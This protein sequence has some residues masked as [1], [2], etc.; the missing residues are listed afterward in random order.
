MSPTQRLNAYYAQTGRADLTPRQMRRHKHK[1]NAQ[2][3]EAVARRE[4][5]ATAR[6]V[7]AL[8]R[9][10]ALVGSAPAS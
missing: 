9:K 3:P 4:D 10:A 2:K 6:L 5:R 1:A 7:E 8:R